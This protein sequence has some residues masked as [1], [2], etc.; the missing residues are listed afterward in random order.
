MALTLQLTS[1]IDHLGF[2]Y[3]VGRFNGIR[4]VLSL[5]TLKKPGE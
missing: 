4:T 1:K 2:S 3:V 5:T